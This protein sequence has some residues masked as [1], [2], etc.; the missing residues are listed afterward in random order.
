M[1]KLIGVVIR[2]E[3]DIR[4]CPL[5]DSRCENATNKGG[6]TFALR[7]IPSLQA[8]TGLG[9]ASSR[10]NQTTYFE[11]IGEGI[12]HGQVISSAL[13]R[14]RTPRLPVRTAT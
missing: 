9:R 8:S 7:S 13:T 2:R 10:F 14:R 12:G 3:G 6:Y 1:K 5:R 11:G 4:L